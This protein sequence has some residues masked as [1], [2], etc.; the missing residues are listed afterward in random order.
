MSGGGAEAVTGG[1]LL[2]VR[3]LR[4]TFDTPAGTVHAVQGVD[5]VV[6]AG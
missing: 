5:L 4:V 2:E 6:S 3:D 1:P